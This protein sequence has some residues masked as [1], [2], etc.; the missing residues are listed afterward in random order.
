M[1]L[2][3]F[4]CNR[5]YGDEYGFPDLIIPDNIWQQIS[6]TKNE[7]GLLCPSCICKRVYDLGI[8]CNAEFR[9]GPFVLYN[10]GPVI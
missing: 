3:C 5:Q 1:I 7:G 2:Y 4:D 6:P 9:S 10:D 8:T